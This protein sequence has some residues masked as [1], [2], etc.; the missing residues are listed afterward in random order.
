MATSRRPANPAQGEAELGYA[1]CGTSS[2]RRSRRSS[3][4]LADGA[5]LR[6]WGWFSASPVLRSLTR[7]LRLPPESLAVVMQVTGYPLQFDGLVERALPGD[8]LALKDGGSRSVREGC[9]F[10][11]RGIRLKRRAPR[12]QRDDL[13][14]LQDIPRGP[15]PRP[16]V[17]SWATPGQLF[18]DLPGHPERTGGT[19]S[20]KSA[21]LLREERHHA[22]R[23]SHL[24]CRVEPL[25]AEDGRPPALG[26]ASSCARTRPR[27]ARPG[28]LAPRPRHI[29]PRPG[30]MAH[31]AEAQ[32][33]GDRPHHA[34]HGGTV[35]ATPG[36]SARVVG[37]P[38][39]TGRA[40]PAR[41]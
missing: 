10:R 30:E 8:A 15:L 29:V 39:V 14:L 21:H 22:S 31:E 11:W 33:R 17:T 13:R 37:A 38:R 7:F 19:S 41:R 16:P 36:H 18:R 20:G 40:T 1:T 23:P 5:W 35:R 9:D 32:R 2:T 25:P 27:W 34:R 3:R 12:L 24:A 4:S 6:P 28:D 26:R